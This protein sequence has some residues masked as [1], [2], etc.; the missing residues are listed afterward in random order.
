VPGLLSAFAAVAATASL[1]LAVLPGAAQAATADP[2]VSPDGVI[3][4]HAKV[5]T[6]ISSVPAFNVADGRSVIN[7]LDAPVTTTFTANQ[8]R[9]FT[10][11]TSAGVQA[12]FF[13]FLT[14][15]VSVNATLS[16]TTA[17]GVSTTTVVPPRTRVLA[18]YGI[19]A[20]DIVYDVQDYVCLGS[21]CGTCPVKCTKNGGP[22][23]EARNVPTVIEGW[24]FTS[25]PA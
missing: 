24:R 17:L 20:F 10:V 4:G 13:M 22:T 6:L 14:V 25:T 7:T 19:E 3:P 18:E 15:S 23:R 8:S 16:R 11:S 5:Y 2:T 12:S 9:T 21:N 1:L